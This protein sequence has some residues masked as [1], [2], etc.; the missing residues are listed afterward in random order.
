MKEYTILVILAL[1]IC[2]ILDKFVFKTLLQSQ[3]KFWIF[4]AFVVFLQTIVDNWLNG[5][6]WL[7]G[8][9]VGPYDDRFYSGIKIWET[10]LENY[11][12]GIALIWMNLIFIEY[13]RAI[14]SKKL[15]QV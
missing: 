2:F 6:W 7:N 11:F 13:W 4:I 12:F 10:P 15:N 14:K 5:R 9:L 1:F 3:K 8:Y